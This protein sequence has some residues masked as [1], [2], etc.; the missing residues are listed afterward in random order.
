MEVYMW[1]WVGMVWGGVGEGV[2]VPSFLTLIFYS[3][4]VPPGHG[5]VAMDVDYS[6]HNL[7]TQQKTDEISWL[8]LV[9]GIKEIR[10]LT[11][12]FIQNDGVS[13]AII[14]IIFIHF[15]LYESC[16]FIMQSLRW[17]TSRVVTYPL[18]ESTWICTCLVCVEGFLAVV[19]SQSFLLASLIVRTDIASCFMTSY[20][21]IIVVSSYCFNACEGAI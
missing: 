15:P 8:I 11:H 12:Y 7:T 10:F 3:T 19:N 4:I 20:K 6:N 5:I 21:I 13:I 2:P 16:I 9:M 18:N 17:E 1:A 14:Y